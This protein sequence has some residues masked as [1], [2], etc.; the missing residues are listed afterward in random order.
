[1]SL[2]TFARRAK[3]VSKQ[4]AQAIWSDV[5]DD[6]LGQ[7]YPS[8]PVIIQLPINDI[9]NSRCIMCDI[10]RKEPDHELTPD[11]LRRILKDPL[12]GA[13]QY[14]GISGGEPTLRKDL[15]DIGRVLVET[16]PSLQ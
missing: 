5:R 12:F 7:Y 3:G 9:C 16:L 10:W 14:V 6:R 13:V 2:I 8:K 4:L 11:E 15:P 1:M